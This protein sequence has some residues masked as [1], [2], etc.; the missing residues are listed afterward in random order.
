MIFTD[1]HMNFYQTQF[2]A[3]NQSPLLEHYECKRMSSIIIMMNSE[4]EDYSL[5]TTS[6]LELHSNIL[7]N[8][9]YSCDMLSYYFTQTNHAQFIFGMNGRV[10]MSFS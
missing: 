7:V 2:S 10:K 3:Q 5:F 4:V 8:R 6:K 1:K 9:H